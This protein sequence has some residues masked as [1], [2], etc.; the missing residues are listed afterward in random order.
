MHGIADKT[1]PKL[2][3]QLVRMLDQQ[4]W[5]WGCDVKHDSGNLLVE[6]GFERIPPPN[7]EQA[8]SSIYRLQLSAS[9]RVVLRSFAVF[10]GDDSLGGLLLKRF[11]GHPY[12]APRADLEVL[13]YQESDLPP[14]ERAA[15][16]DTASWTLLAALIEQIIAYETW[17]RTVFGTHYVQKTLEKRKKRPVAS[18]SETETTWESIAQQLPRRFVYEDQREACLSL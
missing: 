1:H 8:G 12:Q 7:Q 11:D 10:Y 17:V 18:A 13:P 15:P 4:F 2:L 16:D 9:N 6:H 14:L 3:Q 5:R